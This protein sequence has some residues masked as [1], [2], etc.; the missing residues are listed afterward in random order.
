MDIFTIRALIYGAPLIKKGFSVL[1]SLAQEGYS[2]AKEVSPDVLEKTSDF[3]SNAA[4]RVQEVGHYAFK[5]GADILEHA[6]M[7]ILDCNELRDIEGDNCHDKVDTAIK[8]FNVLKNK[9]LEGEG[10]VSLVSDDRKTLED[11][12]EVLEFLYIKDRDYCSIVSYSDH[13][14][15]DIEISNIQNLIAMFFEAPNEGSPVE[16]D[17]INPNMTNL[18][19]SFQVKI[20]NNV[21]I[22]NDQDVY[23]T[24]KATNVYGNQCFVKFINGTGY[25]KN[26][27]AETQAS[28]YAYPLEHFKNEVGDV[29]FNLTQMVSGRMYFSVK[30]PMDFY[31]ERNQTHPESSII[32]EPDGFKTR[33]PNYY[34]LHDKIEFTYSQGGLYINPTAVDFFSLPIQLS[35]ESFDNQTNVAGFCNTRDGVLGIFNETIRNVTEG[36]SPSTFTEWNKLKLTF[37]EGSVEVGRPTVLRVMSPGKASGKGDA[38]F[39]DDYLTNQAYGCNYVDEVWAH[40]GQAGNS[41]KIDCSELEGLNNT[42][43]TGH[44][45]EEGLFVFTHTHGTQLKL[46]KPA[47]S[48]F[49]EAG[50]ITFDFPDGSIG[51][52]IGA[53]VVKGLTAA[54][55]VGM[56]PAENSVVLNQKYFQDNKQK[57][58]IDNN[59]LN[60]TDGGPWFNL[61]SKAIGGSACEKGAYTF[62]YDDFI[63]KDGTLTDSNVDNIG[64][65]EITLG[66]MTGTIIPDPY[67]DTAKYN[68]TLT[69]G[70]NQNRAYYNLTHDENKVTPRESITLKEISSPVNVTFNGVEESI[71][72]KRDMILPRTNVTDGIVINKKTD[73]GEYEIAFPGPPQDVMPLPVVCPVKNDTNKYDVTMA[74]GQWIDPSNSSNIKYYDLTYNNGTQLIPSQPQTLH[75]VSSP[76]PITLEGEATELYLK[77]KLVCPDTNL[78]DAIAISSPPQQPQVCMIAFPGPPA[79]WEP[80][81]GTGGLLSSGFTSMEEI[82]DL[83]PITKIPPIIIENTNN[84]PYIYANIT[85]DKNNIGASYSLK[86]YSAVEGGVTITPEYNNPYMRYELPMIISLNDVC[87]SMIFDYYGGTPQIYL[88]SDLKNEITIQYKYDAAYAHNIIFPAPPAGWQP[89]QHTSVEC[90]FVY[91]NIILGKN[92][93]GASYPLICYS[94][95]DKGGLTITP[96]HAGKYIKVDMPMI[97]KF[98]NT[99]GFITADYYGVTPEISLNSDLKN[100]I[101]IKS[102]NDTD[103]WFDPSQPMTQYNILKNTFDIKF[104]APPADWEPASGTGGL[105]SSGFTSME[106]IHDLMPITK[107]PPIIIEN[108]NNHPYIYAN[109]TLDKNNI[110]ASY[111]LKYYSAVEGGVTITPEYN[112]PYMRY[113][114]PM[115]I[116]LNDVCGSMIFDYYGGTPQ[117]YLKSDLKNEITIQYKYDAAYAHNIIFPAPPAGWQ[118]TQ[119]TSVEC[120]FVYANIILG[121]NDAGASYPLICYSC[122]DKG[123]LTITPEHAGKYIKVDMPMIMKFNNTHGFITA[124]YYGVTPEISLNSDLKNEITIKSPNDTDRWF[125]PSQPMTQ[126]NILKNTF[127]IKF[128]APPADWEPAPE[129]EMFTLE[130]EELPLLTK[131]YNVTVF[132]NVDDSSKSAYLL[133]YG[134]S[135]IAP[136]TITTFA[137]VPTPMYFNFAGNTTGISLMEP[138]VLLTGDRS[139]ISVGKESNSLTHVNVNFTSGQ[140]QYDPKNGD[141]GIYPWHKNF[142]NLLEVNDTS[143][144]TVSFSSGVKS[145]GNNT[146]SCY[147]LSFKAHTITPHNSS[148]KV[149]K[150]VLSPIQFLYKGINVEAFLNVLQWYS[151]DS[152]KTDDIEMR[153][154]LSDSKKV[155]IKIPAPS[156]G[157]EEGARLYHVDDEPGDTTGSPTPTPT[158]APAPTYTPTPTPTAF[159]STSGNKLPNTKSCQDHAGKTHLD[160]PH[161]LG[162]ST[163]CFADMLFHNDL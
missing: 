120:D 119:H 12:I 2:L 70:Q 50:G 118:P 13:E 58:Y 156:I 113:E 25:C 36:R 117:I 67:T 109:I 23:V 72:V 16:E 71:Y 48:S 114:L 86:Y 51:A 97:M 64:L 27:T 147:D 145:F 144:Y 100:E 116:S 91:A 56:L 75:Q 158:P 129:F 52:T 98:N 53:I 110:G 121:K 40:Y 76:I 60:N 130:E 105:L 125:D 42:V 57:F 45:N 82:H 96:E 136:N 157:N 22:A 102:P 38:N 99:H 115:I 10:S 104:P 134:A 154:A 8:E 142:G 163:D 106:E 74:L 37:D 139:L 150:D 94:C 29:T 79:D 61:Y 59:Y 31:I 49:F 14:I 87:G 1:S 19:K 28:N 107:I 92:D 39:P 30:Y 83:M 15:C 95:G 62:A 149:F 21:A 43:V 17:V 151:S 6:A 24:T 20:N 108:T 123:G 101:T 85:L 26:M 11:A 47:S 81:S 68:I 78:S 143:K 44:V 65:V 35:Q 63:G 3:L 4:D 160:T 112:N 18:I 137:D 54:F 90:D 146:V 41:I 124:D 73:V 133:K 77:E 32:T 84:H 148:Q 5:G 132:F 46:Q 111:S 69:L 152:G 80:A 128:P 141:V 88:K 140:H 126:Y 138:Q 153:K 66:N 155:E 9:I 7:H 33:D 89:T 34:K 122:G 127:D 162:H 161:E 159:F 131:G 55:N 135:V 93:A 103:R